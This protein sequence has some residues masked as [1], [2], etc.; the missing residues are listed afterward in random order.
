MRILCESSP[1]LHLIAMVL[2]GHAQCF[3]FTR[4]PFMSGKVYQLGRSRR[5][6]ARRRL[7]IRCGRIPKKGVSPETSSP[8]RD[9]GGRILRRLLLKMSVSPETSSKNGDVE[10]AVLIFGSP[11]MSVSLETSSKNGD[12]EIA[13][14]IFGSPKMSVS[15]ETSSKNWDAEKALLRP[16]LF[17]TSISPETSSKSRDSRGAGEFEVF[18]KMRLSPETSSKKWD[19]ERA[20]SRYILGAFSEDLQD[21]PRGKIFK[22]NQWFFNNP[23]QK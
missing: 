17:K 3:P 13:V 16:D 10:I 5:G 22:K 8:N 15:P 7:S 23:V 14:L 1:M 19:G 6:K 11:K 4:F 18:S 12:I 2:Q 20:L 9:L 21:S